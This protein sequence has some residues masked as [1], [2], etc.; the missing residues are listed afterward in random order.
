MIPCLALGISEELFWTLNPKRLH[1]YLEAE[2]LIQ[3]K[4]DAEMWRMGMYVYNAVRTAVDNVLNGR[5]SQA[6]YM[7][8]PLLEQYKEAH[9]EVELT[10]E[11]EM[12]QVEAFFL[13][14]ETL[15]TN[16]KLAKQA[17]ESEKCQKTETT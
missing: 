9:Q 16:A 17:K 13:S 6:K 10:E 2:K 8:K 4:R 14:L 3:E 15:S 1:P 7:D 11:D 12:K 5:K